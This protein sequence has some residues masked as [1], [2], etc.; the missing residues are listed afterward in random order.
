MIKIEILALAVLAQCAAFAAVKPGEN[1]L[2]NGTFEAD[3]QDIPPFWSPSNTELFKWS[4]A[5]GPNGLPSVAFVESEKD[6]K[7]EVSVRQYGHRLVPGGRY[8]LSA[9]VRTKG[10]SSR[11]CGIVMA[12]NGWVKAAG[13]GA[14]PPDTDGAWKKL[15]NEFVCFEGTSFFAALYVSGVKG[16]FEIADVRLEAVDEKALAGT[17]PTELSKLQNKPRVLPFAP[18]LE[19][20]PDDDRRVTFRFF[21]KLP[22]GVTLADCDFVLKADDAAGEVRRPLAEGDLVLELPKGAKAGVLTAT[23]VVRAKGEKVSEDRFRFRTVTRPQVNATG[24]RRLNNLATEVLKAD[25]GGATKKDFPFWTTRDGWTYTAVKGAATDDVTV[26][27]DGVEVISC[28]TPRLETVRRI[29]AG[30]HTLTVLGAPKATAVVR[31]IAEILSYSPGTSWIPENGGFGWGFQEKY[32][33]PGLTTMN[34]AGSHKGHWDFRARGYEW[35]AN[36]N[37]TWKTVDEMLAKLGACDGLTSPDFDGVTCDELILANSDTIYTYGLG[38]N[39]FEVRCAPEKRIYTWIVGKPSVPAVDHSIFSAGVNASRGEGKMLFE[40]YCRTRDNEQDARNYLDSYVGDTIRR[41]RKWYPLAIPS[42]SVVLGN[43]NQIPILTLEQHPEVDYKYY[44]DMQLQLAATDPS[45]DGLGGV[46]YWGSY[47]ADEELHRW[48]FALMRHYVFEGNT[49]MLSGVHGFSYIP[50]LL[51]NGDFRGSFDGWTTAGDVRTDAHSGFAARSQC[52]WGGNGGVGDTFAA[53]VKKPGEVASAS[54][55]VKGLVPGRKYRLQFTTFDVK[56]VKAAKIDP[57]P[58]GLGVKPL[59]GVTVDPA[60]TWT[61][62]DRRDKGRYAANQGVARVV[63][64]NVVF[65]ADA[66]ETTVTITNEKAQDGEDLGVNYV[67]VI[68]YY[69]R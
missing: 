21:G 62:V 22:D 58:I 44:L 46:G 17:Q 67:R 16:T 66:T 42:T 41:Y 56:D 34:G 35:V 69:P 59:A 18:L 20:I 26:R 38:L 39:E 10:F 25:L 1:I 29:K 2:L 65:T 40:A 23:V 33:L 68:P 28:T 49:N 63:L 32:V 15:S 37:T 7:G 53:F 36:L 54:Q 64:N 24:H 61:H 55:V 9:W 3:Q 50:N 52:R 60:Q 19:K 12:N 31:Q 47:Y 51:K 27:L 4:P 13:A 45:C 5:N 11:G 43:F 14:I 6:D 57:K 8:R 48:S 30:P